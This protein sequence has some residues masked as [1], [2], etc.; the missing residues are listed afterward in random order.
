MLMLFPEGSR[1][2]TYIPRITT[3]GFAL[4]LFL[5]FVSIGVVEH[6][7]TLVAIAHVDFIP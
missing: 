5:L 1:F 2:K 7:P 3:I 6:E 4:F